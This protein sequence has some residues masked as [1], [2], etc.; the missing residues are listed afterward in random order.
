MT[1]EEALKKLADAGMSVD[2]AFAEINAA[3]TADVP[4]D[5]MVKMQLAMIQN[6][7]ETIEVVVNE[8]GLWE[9]KYSS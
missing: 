3:I 6:K 5:F 9:E 1:K 7:P 8:E 2:E 4:L